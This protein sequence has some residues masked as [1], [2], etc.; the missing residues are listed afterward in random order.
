MSL[1]FYKKLH[2]KKK[3]FDPQQGPMVLFKGKW[4]PVDVTTGR[5]SME[6]AIDSYPWSA[7]R[8]YD[9]MLRFATFGKSFTNLMATVMLTPGEFANLKAV[10]QT[11]H[12]SER[13]YAHAFGHIYNRLKDQKP[14]D[15]TLE[16]LEAA[17][18][19]YTYG[20]GRAEGE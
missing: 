17:H 2:P 4:S 6:M 10:T 20:Q 15:F 14:Q 13:D 9:L 1:D 7:S 12:E 19:T 11:L 5:S 16:A 8:V 18:Q 3:K